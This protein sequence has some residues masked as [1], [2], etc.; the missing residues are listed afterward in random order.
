MVNN[1]PPLKVGDTVILSCSNK[2]T[3]KKVVLFKP[4]NKLCVPNPKHFGL[5]PIYE[6]YD[7]KG[8][9]KYDNDLD[10]IKII[11]LDSNVKK[12]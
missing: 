8:V 12:D 9:H 7:I 2:N 5:I 6:D 4:T 11:Q 1:I 10:I 3:T